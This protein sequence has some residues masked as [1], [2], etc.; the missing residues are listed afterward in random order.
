MY[1]H[2]WI[3]TTFTA[4]TAI[5]I[6]WILISIVAWVSHLGF[7]CQHLQPF[8]AANGYPSNNG[9]PDTLSFLKYNIPNAILFVLPHSLLLPKTLRKYFGKHGRLLYN[10][11]AAMSLH[12]FLY[13]FKPLQT[14]ILMHL[15]IYKELH[16]FTSVSMLAFASYSF[17]T[18]PET[19][20]LL[21]INL[22]LSR[23]NPEGRRAPT[24][25]D[26]ITWMGICTWRK[27]EELGSGVLAFVLFTGLSILPQDL[28]L[29]D[30]VVRSVAAIYLRYRS[31]AFRKWIEQI[32]GAHHA[33]WML[34]AGLLSGALYT[35]WK[36][37][38][39]KGSNAVLIE[40]LAVCLVFVLRHFEK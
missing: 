17:C 26:A 10:L 19:Y 22:S 29:G 25:M 40:V 33:T 13:N 28:T 15:P 32:E 1:C 34:R 2:P 14:P 7:R 31:K 3:N 39:I 8:L 35:A 11:M 4:I 24:S 38:E 16:V 5:Y 36:M 20:D 30:V 21:G 18:A 37:N 12:L 23:K 9:A 6:Q 27:G